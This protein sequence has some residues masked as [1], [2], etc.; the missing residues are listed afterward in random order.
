M[1]CCFGNSGHIS[2]HTVLCF[3]LS[4]LLLHGSQ[5]DQFCS[6]GHLA[7][8]THSAVDE[9]IGTADRGGFQVQKGVILFCCLVKI[10]EI[11]ARLGLEI[12]EREKR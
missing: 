6:R 8:S 1:D 3:I 9:R 5:R 11:W 10:G 12:N 2:L 4:Y 7:M